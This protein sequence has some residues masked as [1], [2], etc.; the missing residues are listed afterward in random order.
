MKAIDLAFGVL[1]SASYLALAS[2]SRTF[3]RTLPVTGEVDLDVT[4]NPGGVTIT[5]GS[6]ASVRVHAVI[7]PLYGVVDLGLA[8]ANIRALE[9]NPP[10]EQLGNR[11]RV[12]Y[13]SNPENLR[14]VSIH[15]DV[16]TPRET[17]V[18]AKTSSGGIRIDGIA[19]PVFADSSSGRIEINNV[20]AEIEVKNSSG[21]VVVRK[22]G[23]HVSA[24]NGSG[25][26]QVVS[27]Q[28]SVDVETT[29]GRTEVSEVR[30]DV[31]S[32]THSG[33]ISIDNATGAVT[34]NNHSGSIDV[35]QLAG[36]VQAE[37]GSGAIRIS[38]IS[39]AT[40][41]ARTD[42]GPIKVNLPNGRGYEIDA[43]SNS[44]KVSGP[45]THGA[46]RIARPHHLKGQ[47]GEGG[48]LVDLHTRSSKISVN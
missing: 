30:G 33:S 6:A 44:G 42:S 1:L 37:T 21:A 24:R 31:R 27:A 48:P 10:V 9:Q 29:S 11:I 16:E 2:E 15:F 47:I 8:D 13:V 7:R 23:G 22:P 43:Q 28:G 19:G 4:S 32:R 5:A 26:I 17:R 3:D 41:T 18:H 38:Q 39:P 40:I 20:A 12:G 45:I 25:G 35:F 34:A 14:G 36:S 46:E